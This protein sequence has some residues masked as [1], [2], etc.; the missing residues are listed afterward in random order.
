MTNNNH[1]HQNEVISIVCRRIIPGYEKDY[2]DWL[3]RYLNM[4]KNVP[5]YIGTT[6]IIPGGS[7]S[8]IRYIIHRFID[9]IS[10]EKWEKSQESIEMLDEVNKY[11][12]RHYDTST[13]L[14]TWFNLPDINA[15]NSPPP[16][17]K[18]AIVVFIAAYTISLLS[19]SI[20]RPI[21]GQ[22]LPLA[23]NNLIYVIIMVSSLTY[24]VMPFMNRLL[25][26]WLYP[27]P[28]TIQRS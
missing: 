15:I 19:Q 12:I 11:S 24:F 14:E 18:M 3:R 1:H 28:K 27:N 4:E 13:G 16:R 10:M 6:V 7:K 21:I 5:G 25:K 22:Q 23:V 2:D 26:R 17:W 20:L 9:K 8:T